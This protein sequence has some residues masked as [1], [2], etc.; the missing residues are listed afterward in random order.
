MNFSGM[1]CSDIPYAENT[2]DIKSICLNSDSSISICNG[3]KYTVPEFIYNYDPYR[4][5]GLASISS[6]GIDRL[7]EDAKKQNVLCDQGGYYYLRE[8]CTDLRR[9]MSNP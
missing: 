6:G 2:D 8:L 9:R 7:I 1:K 3:K 5:I 4:E